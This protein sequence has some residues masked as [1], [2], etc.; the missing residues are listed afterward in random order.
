MQRLAVRIGRAA[1]ADAAEVASVLQEA[2]AWLAADGRALWAPGRGGQSVSTALLAFART[3]T[4]RLGRPWLR[5][6]C[7][8]DRTA[9]R[10]LYECFGFSLHSVVSKGAR[11]FARYELLIAHG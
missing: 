1:V 10:T 9:L 7:V 4:A 2:A 8:A 5:L 3:R 6:D 11:S